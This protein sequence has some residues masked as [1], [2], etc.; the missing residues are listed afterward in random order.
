MPNFHGFNFGG[1]PGANA[2]F[3]PNVMNQAQSNYNQGMAQFKPYTKPT[4]QTT[5]TPMLPQKTGKTID[6]LLGG[7]KF[8]ELAPGMKL[9]NRNGTY[10]LTGG[11]VNRNG[12]MVVNADGGVDNFS[13][14]DEQEFNSLLRL[15]QALGLM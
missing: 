3:G 12:Q 10:M 7:K 8:I 15:Q 1:F 2:L 14:L 6:E 9:Q 13:N 5:Q 4:T 11:G